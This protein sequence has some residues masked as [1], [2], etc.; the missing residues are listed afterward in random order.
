[1]VMTVGMG[2]LCYFVRRNAMFDGLFMPRCVLLRSWRHCV[3]VVMSL[4]VLCCSTAE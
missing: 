1:M 3:L 2:P 4:A